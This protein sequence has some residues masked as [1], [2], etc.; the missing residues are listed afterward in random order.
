[1]EQRIVGGTDLKV[2]VVSSGP[3]RLAQNP[4]DA[5]LQVHKRAM[6]AAIDRG[7]NF[8]HSSYEYGVRWMMHEV[9]SN[10]PHRHDL[11]HVIKAPV[12]DWDDE[13]YDAMKFER[14]IDDALRDLCTD[15]IA[16]VQWMWQ[17]RLRE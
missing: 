5:D 4:D 6:R 15:R 13:D 7:I 10:H 16:I 14:I 1:M 12:P 17:K 2:S 3:M 8:M 9:L 11:H